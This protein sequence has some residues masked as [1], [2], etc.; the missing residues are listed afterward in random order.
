[1]DKITVPIEIKGGRIWLP[2]T[3]QEHISNKFFKIYIEDR[4]FITKLTKDGRFF[5]PVEIRNKLNIFDGKKCNIDIELLES[6]E[7][8]KYFLTDN[9]IDLLFFVEL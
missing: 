5:I 1:M 7:K 6:L 3:I 2:I 4:S 9:Y 8:P